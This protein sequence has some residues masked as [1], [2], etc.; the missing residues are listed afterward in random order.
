MNPFD[1]SILHFLNGFAQRSQVFDEFVVLVCMNNFL[2]GALV[3]TIVWYLWFQNEGS[4]EKRGYLLAG[5]SASFAGLVI[6]KMLAFAIH[7]AR[8]FNDP[9]LVLRIPY[10]IHAVAWEG[11]NSF[12]SDHAVLFFALATGIFLASRPVGLLAYSYVTLF[13]C[14]PRIYLG[15]HFPTD[16]LGG[17]IIGLSTTWLAH[18]PGIRQPLT[19][20]ACRW[21]DKRPGLFYAFSFLLTYLVSELFDPA[22]S[23]VKF[24]LRGHLT[25]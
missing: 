20:C 2:K 5:V 8:P 9:Q 19:R 21:I 3:F 25:G 12:P 10:G 7:R 6:A 1:A 24:I 4:K 14:I 18:F 22:L 15:I 23:I 11:L 17:A 16:I 13:I